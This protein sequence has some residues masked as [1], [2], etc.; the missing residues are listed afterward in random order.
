[1]SYRLYTRT[2]DLQSLKQCFITL[3]LTHLD[4]R[5]SPSLNYYVKYW[6]IDVDDLID[7]LLSTSN[8]EIILIVSDLL[9]HIT[10]RDLRAIFPQMN[11][12]IIVGKRRSRCDDIEHFFNVQSLVDHLSSTLRD[13]RRLYITF[14][15]WPIERTSH[16][17]N[18]QT[19]KFLWY[20][21][22]YHILSRL[23]NTS[24]A[25]AEMLESIKAFHT[26]TNRCRKK[27]M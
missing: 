8:Q 24:V 13:R 21:Y 11:R 15:S 2:Q 4:F 12:I 10:C 17:L 20:S 26:K 22:F 7:F 14:D 16:D 6:F 27:I 23:N 19:P 5:S 1:M 3:D 9:A 25:R 18:K